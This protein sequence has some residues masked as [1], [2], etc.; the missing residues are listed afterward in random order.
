M[1]TQNEKIVMADGREIE[2]DGT[3]YYVKD[4]ILYV[5]IPTDYGASYEPIG[6]VKE[7]IE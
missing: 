1:T 4:G 3:P 2:I 7:V 6:K 5:Y